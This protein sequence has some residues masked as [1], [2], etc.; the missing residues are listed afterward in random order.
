MHYIA[1]NSASCAGSTRASMKKLRECQLYVS[2]TLVRRLMDC[3]V[4][5]GNDGALQLRQMS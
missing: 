2:Q 5:L 1:K 4:K 3:R